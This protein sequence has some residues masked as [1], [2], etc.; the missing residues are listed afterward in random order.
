MNIEQRR[1]EVV[2]LVGEGMSVR[3][4]A[5]LFD[6]SLFSIYTDLKFMG[7]PASGSIN[8]KSIETKRKVD[9][10]LKQGVSNRSIEL[11]FGLSSSY[12]SWRRRKLGLQV[13]YRSPPDVLARRR[14][15]VPALVAQGLSASAIAEVLEVAVESIADD[16]RMTMSFTRCF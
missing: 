3:E 13:R 1:K 11:E 5:Q 12:V 2:R 10:R 15:I 16:K 9:E 6:R 14:A 8:R 4:I 7:V